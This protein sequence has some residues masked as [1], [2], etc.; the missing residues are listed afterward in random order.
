MA[1]TTPID[2]ALYN[3]VESYLSKI[4]RTFTWL[5][6]KVGYTRQGLKTSII[7]RTIRL[8]TLEKITDALNIQ[9]STLVNRVSDSATRH[10]QITGIYDS[11]SSLDKDFL[12]T[13]SN[14]YDGYLDK[15]SFLKDYYVWKVIVFVLNS[16][17]ISVKRIPAFP[18]GYKDSP[19]FLITPE[20][21]YELKTLIEFKPYNYLPYSK[22]PTSR[23]GLIKT[24]NILLGFYFLLF[25]DDVLN[26]R[27]LL[28]DGLITD[29]EI[30][31]YWKKW[32]SIKPMTAKP[33]T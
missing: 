29:P 10:T 9:L 15:I 26:I 1:N 5:A 13:L 4:D 25:R 19:E 14:R 22:M 7:N 28:T 2:L 21:A 27:S 23:Q 3:L 6:R 18:I 20:Q 16:N 32:K 24:T 33:L 12:I 31:K 17:P 8:D 30:T 11:S